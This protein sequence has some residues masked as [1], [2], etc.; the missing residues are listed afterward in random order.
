MPVPTEMPASSL[1]EAGLSHCGIV[2]KAGLRELCAGM[3]P[4]LLARLGVDDAGSAIVAALPYGEGPPGP[5]SWALPPAS[6]TGVEGGPGPLARLARFAR[7][8]WYGELGARLKDGAARIRRRLAEGGVDPGL[9]NE[10]RH[11]A[12]SRL[13][14]RPLAIAA[15]L[16]KPGRHGLVMLP[17]HGSAV[18]LGLLLCPVEF[19]APPTPPSV[20]M[21]PSCADCRACVAACPTGALDSGAF[22][23]ELCLQHWSSL[24]GPLPA[25]IEAAWGDRLYGCDS[26]QEACPRFRPDASASTGRGLLGPG[27]PARWLLATPEAEIRAALRGSVLGMKWISAAALKRNA[28]LASRGPL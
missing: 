9:P 18:A 11:F 25:A 27:L 2:G 3:P 28:A 26:C 7:A 5:P 6:T 16:G 23:R 8:D 13:P 24:P 20:G 19:E 4:E 22:V 17:G 21:D 10:W 15:G 14:E 1:D 12:N